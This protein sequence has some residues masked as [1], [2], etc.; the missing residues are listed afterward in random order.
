MASDW[1]KTKAPGAPAVQPAGNPKLR[2]L[3][4][5]LATTRDPIERAR[6]FQDI[7]CH[8]NRVRSISDPREWE[9]RFHCHD[10]A[11]G[12]AGR[13]GSFLFNEALK[14]VGDPVFDGSIIEEACA[15]GI[16]KVRPPGHSS[17]EMWLP[18]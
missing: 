9:E 11:L 18:T 12:V 10:Y 6:L 1:E 7:S 2:R 17:L 5:Q 16:M 3:L 4:D 14:S 15:R 13:P 8:T